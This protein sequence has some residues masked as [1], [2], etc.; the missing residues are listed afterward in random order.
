MANSRPPTTKNGSRQS[1]TLVSTATTG[2]PTTTADA[3][4]P[5][6]TPMAR[7]RFSGETT[8]LMAAM[9][10]G[11]IMDPPSPVPMSKNISRTS[12]R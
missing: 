9:L 3:M 12:V 5:W 10:L 7:P 6:A 8:S 2:T 11:G 1:A 4:M